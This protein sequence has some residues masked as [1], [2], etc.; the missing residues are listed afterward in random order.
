MLPNIKQTLCTAIRNRRRVSIR[1]KNQTVPRILEPH[2]LYDVGGGQLVIECYQVRGYSAGGRTPPF[3]RPF[4][5]HKINSLNVLDEL[6]S[7]RIDEGFQNIARLVRGEMIC[8]AAMRASDYFYFNP[9]IQGPPP[10][11][12]GERPTLGLRKYG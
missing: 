12:A 10:P 3:W 8:V 6:F 9:E 2:I 5:L 7:P 11:D 1:Y 4:S